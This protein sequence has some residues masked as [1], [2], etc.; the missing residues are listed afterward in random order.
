MKINRETPKKLLYPSSTSNQMGC[1]IIAL[2]KFVSIGIAKHGRDNRQ[3]PKNCSVLQDPQACIVAKEK[4]GR[5]KR[6]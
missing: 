1:V 3:R 2:V 6:S 4:M 5:D